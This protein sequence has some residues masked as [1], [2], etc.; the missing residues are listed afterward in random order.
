MPS[1]HGILVVDDDPNTRI[2][3]MHLLAGEGYD[4]LTAADGQQAIDMLEGGIRP[5][6]ML[7][8][9]TMPRVG[10]TDL[11]EYLHSDLELRGIPTIVITGRAKDEVKVKT[12]WVPKFRKVL[13]PKLVTRF[14]QIENKLDA[15]LRFDAVDRIPLVEDDPK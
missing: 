5:G 8:D 9:L 7:I 2:G 12:A 3:L 4:V 15:M 11:I 10:G 13:S 14:Y 6:L 1:R